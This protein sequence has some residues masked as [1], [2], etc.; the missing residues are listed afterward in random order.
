MGFLTDLVA[1]IRRDLDRNPLDD[2][3][4]LARSLAMPPT[5]DLAAALRGRVPAVIAEV[6][7]ASPSAGLIADRDPA[8][9]AGAYAA[10]G[11]AAVS[12]L[13]E[14]RH[15][16]GALADL[17]AVRT[18][19]ELPVLRK[20]FLVHPSQLIESRA[21]G[22][23]A[24]L[25]ITAAVTPAELSALLATARDLGLGVLLETHSEGD[26]DVALATDAV[27]IGVNARDLESLEVDPVAARGRLAR[28]P[29]DRIAVLESGIA[30]R[31]DVRAAVEAGASAIL[32]GEALM[33]ATDPVA[34]LRALLGEE[35]HR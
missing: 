34:A 20:D 21:S 27:V 14:R 12:V 4:L 26:L 31:R 13:T 11:A 15:F 7:R 25:L 1:E 16:G 24:V 18:A 10:A 32:V 17:R 22:A 23:D 8:A 30:S 28:I 35:S 19:V 9:Q 33:R 2:G 6:K 5:R 29:P 3:T